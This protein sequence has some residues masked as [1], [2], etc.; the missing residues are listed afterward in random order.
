MF[1]PTANEVLLSLVVLRRRPGRSVSP[2]FGITQIELFC[3]N[4]VLRKIPRIVSIADLHRVQGGEVAHCRPGHI[5][6]IFY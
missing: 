6:R 5:E 4:K 3:N 1:Y 2:L